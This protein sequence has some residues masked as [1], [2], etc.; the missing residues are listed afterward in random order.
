M[1]PDSG[2]H[3][4]IAE[5]EYHADPRSLSS[6][7]AKTIYA[8]GAAAYKWEREN[9][10]HKDAWDFG[11]VVHALVLGV[12]EYEVIDQSSWRTKAAMEARLEAREAGKTPILAK[13][14]AR[15]EDVR[16]AVMENK[17]A[18]SILSDG[19]AE[20]SAWA[21][22]PDTGVLIRGRF[23]YLRDNAIVDLKTSYK[24][25]DPREWERTAWN[26]HYGLQAAWY[27]RLLELNSE[28]ERPF[29]WV[30]VCTEQPHEVYIHQASDALI[31]KGRE[32][33]DRA[34]AT[35]AAAVKTGH[36]PGLADPHEIHTTNPP[37]WVK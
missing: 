10:E 27:M 14:F 11:S 19:R 33:A 23:D 20:I 15:A 16:D 26:L 25:V 12:G 22:D 3:P 8:K 7:G 9:P 36:W 4:G 24:P 32:Q 5:T 30:T 34:L 21:T 18:A 29:L 6:T 28:P 13:D 17:L 37:A 31:E 1:L 35:Y 2:I